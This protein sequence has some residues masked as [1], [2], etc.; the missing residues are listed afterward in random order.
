MA[1]LRDS[2]RAWIVTDDS[3]LPKRERRV[4]VNIKLRVAL[5]P[6]RNKLIPPQRCA[7]SAHA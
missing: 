7:P 5:V 6:R 4:E 3:T 1:I 2:V